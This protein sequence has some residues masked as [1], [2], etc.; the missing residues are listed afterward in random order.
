MGVD[1]DGHGDV[2]DFVV[3]KELVAVGFKAVEHFA[4]QGQDG[5]CGFVARKLGRAAGG[6]AFHQKKLVFAQVFAFAVGEFTGQH[7]HAGAFF[8]LDFFH[9]AHPRLCLFDGQVGNFFARVYILVEPQF[10]GVAG[11]GGH[12]LERIAVGELV[13]GLALE[14]RVE[15]AGAEH[16]GHAVEDVVGLHF[17]AARQ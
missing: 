5:L 8:L 4:A 14:L 17:N 9:R 2:V 6:I 12:Q 16:K 10:D 3:A 13:F 11:Y 15:H 7:G 1:A